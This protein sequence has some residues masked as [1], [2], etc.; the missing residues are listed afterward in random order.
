MSRRL[1][2]VLVAH[3]S[4]EDLAGRKPAVVE[5]IPSGVN[6]TPTPRPR[7]LGQRRG[8]LEARVVPR[9]LSE[10]R[11]VEEEPYFPPIVPNTEIISKVFDH[12]VIY[13]F[14]KAKR[15]F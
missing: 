15:A 8:Q 1:T 2:A 6:R 5:S 4:T 12:I 9:H 3:F 11:V 10:R 14:E 7:L 13:I